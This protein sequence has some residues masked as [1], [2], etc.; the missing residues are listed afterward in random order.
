MH[1][2]HH[3]INS[4]PYLPSTHL[5]KQQSLRSS[6]FRHAMHAWLASTELILEHTT[7]QQEGSIGNWQQLETNYLDL[8]QPPDSR[9]I[10]LPQPS[11]WF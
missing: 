9:S 6:R 2:Q 10:T 5:I 8:L 4:T 7:L 1:D 3:G 11:T